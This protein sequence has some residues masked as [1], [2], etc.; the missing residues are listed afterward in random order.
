MINL[1]YVG[2]FVVRQKR[3]DKLLAL[4]NYLEKYNCD[5]SIKIF[6]SVNLER[7]EFRLFDSNFRFQFLGFKNDWI[8]FIR[9]DDIMILVSDYEGCPLSIL[10]AFH[11]NNKKIAVLDVPGIDS[12]L[13]KNCIFTDVR[14]MSK[15]IRD[16]SDLENTVDLS[17]F[18][19][20]ARFD[21]EVID[22]YH[23]IKPEA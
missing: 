2:R 17:T 14:Q 15:A 3:V 13:S 5:F 7:E 22:F 18:F 10:E 20:E 9:R 21:Q 19:D 4:S 6:A 16:N 11:N 1:Y 12:Y 8:K 23:F